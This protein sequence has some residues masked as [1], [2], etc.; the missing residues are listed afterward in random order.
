VSDGRTIGSDHF[1]GQRFFNPGTETGRG[2]WQVLRWMLGRRRTAWPRWVE[3]PPPPPLP[4]PPPG[5]LAVTFVNQSTFLL[6]LPGATLL[7]DPIWSDRASPL[8]WAGPRRAR[9]PGLAFNDL[10]P[11]GLVLLSHNHYDHLDLPTLRRLRDAWNPLVV[12]GLGLGRYLER[13]GF[14]RVVELDWWETYRHAERLEIT[15]TPARHFTRRGLFDTNR[16]LWGGFA[17]R[18]PAGLVYFAGD[19]AYGDHFAE[20]RQRLGPPDLALLPFAAYEPRWFMQASHVNPE[21]AVRAHLDV[22]ARLSVG[23]HFGTFQLTDEGIDEPIRALHE[24]LGRHG[25]DARHFRVPA[26]GET[27]VLP[28]PVGRQLC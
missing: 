13:R 20:I 5:G 9:R 22:G 25:V 17:L 10:A 6:R 19:S 14:R 18:G 23:M 12:T 7:T 27:L 28:E 1:D 26:F 24:A 21:E 16:V 11:V 3:D 2:F 8:S 15:F 4:A